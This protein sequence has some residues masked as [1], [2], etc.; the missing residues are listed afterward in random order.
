MDAGP[1]LLFLRRRFSVVVEGQAEERL[2]GG[3]VL[4]V[5]LQLT[6]KFCELV[7][8][9]RCLRDGRRRCGLG[10]LRPGIVISQ[11]NPEIF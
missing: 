5:G 3:E 4:R 10:L 6:E 9:G 2:L 7:L 11:L 8:E 1:E